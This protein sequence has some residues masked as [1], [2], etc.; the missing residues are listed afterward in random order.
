MELLYAGGLRVSELVGLD[1]GDISLEQMLARIRGKGKKERL[2][3]FGRPAERALRRYLSRR[4]ALLQKRRLH[5]PDN[6]LFLNLRGSRISARSVERNLKEYIQRSA[7]LLDVHPHLLR[8]S[9]ATHLLQNGADLRCI[10]ELMGH[11]SLSTTQK[12]THLSFDELLR[13]YRAS[14]PKAG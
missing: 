14:H 8:H 11:E 3:P 2:V 6:A 13:V 7:L 12:Y 9:F 4:E 5:Q 1:L 10:Q